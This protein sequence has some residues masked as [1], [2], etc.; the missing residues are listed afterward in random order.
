MGGGTASLTVVRRGTPSALCTQ[1]GRAC[2]P[3]HHRRWHRHYPVL[4]PPVVNGYVYLFIGIVVPPAVREA[5]LPDSQYGMPVT[6]MGT[7]FGASGRP[8]L[9]RFPL[10]RYALG[11]TS[12]PTV[13]SMPSVVLCTGTFQ[14]TIYY[15]KVSTDGTISRGVPNGTL[16]GAMEFQWTAANGRYTCSAVRCS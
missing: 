12:A 1:G 5:T 3:G 11:V 15:T 9:L 7:R 4:T 10:A 14:S 13:T 2:G 16:S 6:P 8:P